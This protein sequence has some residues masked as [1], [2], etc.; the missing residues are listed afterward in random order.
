MPSRSA[1][2]FRETP[3]ESI[4]RTTASSLRRLLRPLRCRTV[5]HRL[6]LLLRTLVD[7]LEHIRCHEVVGR[8]LL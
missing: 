5:A 8:E 2:S 3:S 6:D 1:T 7:L 4:D